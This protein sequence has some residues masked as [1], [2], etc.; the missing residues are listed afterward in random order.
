MWKELKVQAKN[1]MAFWLI[2]LGVKALSKEHRTH[3]VIHNSILTN[4][5]KVDKDL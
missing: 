4:K 1:R 3:T 2:N 5:I